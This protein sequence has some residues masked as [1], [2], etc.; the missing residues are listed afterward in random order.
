MVHRSEAWNLGFYDGKEKAVH[1]CFGWKQPC[2]SFETKED[3]QDYL[4]G[5]E[6]GYDS[7]E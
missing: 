5:F 7:V 6:A 2:R 4:D 3:E 1:C